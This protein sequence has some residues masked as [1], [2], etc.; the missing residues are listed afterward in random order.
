MPGDEK[1]THD[2]DTPPDS[3]DPAGICPRCG[4]TSNSMQV[5]SSIDLAFRGDIRAAE[6]DGRYSRLPFERVS[7]F[8]C[9]GCHQ[10]TAVIEELTVGNKPWRKSGSGTLRWPGVYWWPAASGA[11][12]DAAVPERIG[13][14]LGEG[15][16]CLGA[17][18]P[19]AAAVMFGR[20]LEAIVR[21]KGSEAAQKAMKKAL[22]DGLEVMAAE[23]ALSKDLASWAKELRLAR[24]AGG[25]DELVDDV[26][27]EEASNLSKLLDQLLIN[28]YVMPARLRRAKEKA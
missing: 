8:E 14:I 17:R 19:R 23:G 12:V 10:R 13:D 9:Y 27:P 28:L 5:G 6:R 11:S 25:H 2:P 1:P 3:V 15:L 26:T 20:T 7:I 4:L 18:A 16:R 21:D 24:N 22:A